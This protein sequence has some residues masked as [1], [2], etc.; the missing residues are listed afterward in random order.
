MNQK[1]LRDLTY[2]IVSTALLLGV[3]FW[4]IKHFELGSET[5]TE[6]ERKK[7]KIDEFET[8]IADFIENSNRHLYLDSTDYPITVAS[9]QS[10]F[11]SLVNQLDAPLY[12]YK[13]FIDKNNQANAYCAPGGLIVVHKGLLKLMDEP[14]EF[15]AVIAHELGHAELKHFRKRLTRAIG[16]TVITSVIT[17]GDPGMIASVLNDLTLLQYGRKQENEADEFAVNLLEKAN[18]DPEYLISV[19]EKLMEIHSDLKALEWI[20]THPNTEERIK[21]IENSISDTTFHF[22][23]SDI[24]WEAIKEEIK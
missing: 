15:A 22:T 3:S 5:T 8:V 2:L 4:V 6:G 24:N 20:S 10:I 9:L 11:D 23:F 13:L 21:N 19:F 12:D 18:I 17:G 7:G 1:L 16:A 14:N